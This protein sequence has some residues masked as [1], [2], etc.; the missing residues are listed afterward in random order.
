MILS[1]INILPIKFVFGEQESVEAKKKFE[2]QM[3]IELRSFLI[4]R[5]KREFE[6]SIKLLN[7]LTWDSWS[8]LDD[9]FLDAWTTCYSDSYSRDNGTDYWAEIVGKYCFYY[10]YLLGYLVDVY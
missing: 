6:D 2:K 3:E 8:F 9:Y 10:L 7:W 1:Q 5:L 4:E